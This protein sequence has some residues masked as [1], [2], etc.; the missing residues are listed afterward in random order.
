MFV[1]KQLHQIRT[2]KPAL[3]CLDIQQRPLA[4]CT[5]P[6]SYTCA[7]TFV[8]TFVQKLL[9]SQLNRKPALECFD[10]QQGPFSQ[11]PSLARSPE[12]TK[13]LTIPNTTIFY[14]Q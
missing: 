3:K 4:S 12:A 14:L 11:V 9:S 8:R 5:M 10:I 6:I 7:K 1:Q 13:T 2:Q